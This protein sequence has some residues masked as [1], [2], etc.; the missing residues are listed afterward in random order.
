MEKLGPGNQVGVDDVMG[1]R[2]FPTE[3][4]LGHRAPGTRQS[5]GME[6]SCSG[7]ETGSW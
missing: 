7:G 1:E 4:A 3:Q 2:L 6:E 5:Q